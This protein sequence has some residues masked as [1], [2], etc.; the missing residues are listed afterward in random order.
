MGLRHFHVPGLSHLQW[1]QLEK[2]I[3]TWGILYEINSNLGAH[4]T[5]QIIQSVI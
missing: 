4:F 3:P 5:G 2:V 1:V